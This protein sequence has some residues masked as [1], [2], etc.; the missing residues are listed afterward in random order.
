MGCVFSLPHRVLILRSFVSYVSSFYQDIKKQ[1]RMCSR[2]RADYVYFYQPCYCS[3]KQDRLEAHGFEFFSTK[4]R[5]FDLYD[6]SADRFN[7]RQI[8]FSKKFKKKL[9]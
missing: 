9:N 5:H 6:R 3:N 1:V 4:F 8:L 2:V 7:S